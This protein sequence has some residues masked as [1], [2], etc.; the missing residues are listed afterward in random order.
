M[1]C[2][3]LNLSQ[4]SRWQAAAAAAAAIPKHTSSSITGAALSTLAAAATA[5]PAASLVAL[6]SACMVLQLVAHCSHRIQ[7]A[8]TI[9]HVLLCC[10]VACGTLISCP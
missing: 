10:R 9:V 1:R 4:F 5:V 6:S 8:P 7:S 2:E 3:L